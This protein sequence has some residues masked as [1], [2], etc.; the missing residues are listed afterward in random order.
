MHPERLGNGNNRASDASKE[1]QAQRASLRPIR[2]IPRLGIPRSCHDITVGER[3]LPHKVKHER[4]RMGGHILRA[5]TRAVRDCNP[6][7]L[8]PGYI[9]MV[10]ANRHACRNANPR[11]GHGAHGVP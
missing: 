6:P 7:R 11:T 4:Y 3:D 9:H 10:H 5:I 8:K 1:H 2:L